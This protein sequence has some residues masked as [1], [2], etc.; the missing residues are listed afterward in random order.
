[1]FSL[2]V[3][4][5]FHDMLL[6]LLCQQGGVRLMLNQPRSEQ[7]RNEN[8]KIRDRGMGGGGNPHKKRL[9]G[10]LGMGGA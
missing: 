5:F 9:A 8:K 2:S 6:E 7:K 4:F 10:L 1:M 3:R